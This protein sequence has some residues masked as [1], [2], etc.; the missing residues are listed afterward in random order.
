MKVHILGAGPSGISVAW[1]LSRFTNHDIFVYDK[2][3]GVGG[4][5]WEPRGE[6]RDVHAHRALFDNAF[7]N[8][9]SILREMNISWDDAFVREQKVYAKIPTKFLKPVDYA[10]LATLAMKV[11]AFPNVYKRKSVKES[12]GK[13]SSYGKKYVKAITYVM[14]GAG[15]D[16]MT[17]YEFVQN[18]N[19]IGLS[20]MYTQRGPGTPLN[21]SMQKALE[22][23]GVTF[24]GGKEMKHV[25]YYDDGFTATFADGE[26]IND[27][28]LVMCVDNSSALK[29]I[30]DN[31]VD[32]HKKIFE[33]TYGCITVMLDYERPVLYPKELQVA[34]Q[35]EWNLIPEILEG[36]NT[37][38]CVMCHLT[39]EILTTPPDTLKARV[40][41]QLT[42][43]GIPE[44]QNVRIAWGSNWDGERWRFTQSSGVLSVHGQ[45]PFFGRSNK[46]ALCGMMSERH[47]PYSSIEAAVEVG[48][49]FCNK[50]FGTRA[51]LK[52]ILVTDVLIVVIVLMLTILYR[53]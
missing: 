50:T 51:P 41:E 8:T 10:A 26:T 19:H 18:A 21:D 16:V 15:W 39:D 5:W 46:V 23:R 2:K 3:P 53:R 34:I 37:V 45:V 33:S 7:V 6:R 14:D 32:G 22:D 43:L 11:L 25:E 24:V 13:L 12:I 1:E 31:W 49:S 42:N 52:P 4:S 28:M 36:S 47:T 35:T 20:N 29:L 38:A 17:A 40:V 48:R 30:G 27:G 44:P 9:Q